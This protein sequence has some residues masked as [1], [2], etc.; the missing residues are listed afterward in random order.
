VGAEDTLGSLIRT[1]LI[2]QVLNSLT[3]KALGTFPIPSLDLSQMIAGLPPDAKIAIEI[4]EILR[5]GAYNILSG[6]VK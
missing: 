3:G 5:K 4:R 1:V 6:N 2:P